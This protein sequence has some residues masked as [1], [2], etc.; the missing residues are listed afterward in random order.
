MLHSLLRIPNVIKMPVHSKLI[1]KLMQ[2]QTPMGFMRVGE[3]IVH[4]RVDAWKLLLK[5]IGDL[6]YKYQNIL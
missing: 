5:M 4:N 6:L 3:S 1:Y 2:N